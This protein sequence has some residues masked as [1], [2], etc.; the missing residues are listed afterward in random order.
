MTTALFGHKWDNNY[1][2][3]W[4]SSLNNKIPHLVE[5]KICFSSKESRDTNS[6]SN[7]D[8]LTELKDITVK[9]NYG[10]DSQNEG[11]YQHPNKTLKELVNFLSTKINNN[12]E[13]ITDKINA[14]NSQQDSVKNIS[15]ITDLQDEKINNL[16][17]NVTNLRN[18]KFRNMRDFQDTD[19]S[20]NNF[21]H[22]INLI[23]NSFGFIALILVLNKLIKD[24]TISK[25][26][27]TVLNLIVVSIFSVYILINMNTA[28]TRHKTDWNKINFNN[29]KVNEE[30]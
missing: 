3:F 27:G 7:Y 14:I 19:F 15:K 4:A 20:D 8:Y 23:L 25:N 11:A 12:I 21:D 10:N 9:N 28:D 26:I 18:T 29:M 30:I 22:N 2:T 5:R 24:E 6:K 16:S 13:N 1:N 17:N